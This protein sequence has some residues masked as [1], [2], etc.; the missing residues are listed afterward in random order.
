MGRYRMGI[1][2]GGTFTDFVVI[3]LESG[4][5]ETQKVLTTPQDPSEGIMA[6]IERLGIS[7]DEVADISH[8]TTTATN[9]LI[10]RRGARTAFLT[11]EGFRDTLEIRRSNRKELYD[12]QWY[13]PPPLVPRRNR[14][15]IRERMAWDGEVVLPLD[16]AQVLDVVETL[17]IREI[18]AV[19]ICFLHAY[20]HP[21]HERRVREL[22]RQA[23]PDAFVTTSSEITQEFREFERGSTVAAN[24]FLGPRVKLYVQ[25]LTKRLGEAGYQSDVTIMQSNGGVCT[26][27]EAANIPAKLARSGPAGG[28]MALEQVAARTGLENLVGIDIGGTSADVSVI[29]D[30]R[31]KWT[32]PLF[33]EWGLPLLFPSV[34]VESIGAGG[35]SIAWIDEGRALHM[36]PQSAGADPGPACYGYGGTQ[37]TSTDAHVVLGRVSTDRFLDGRL[38]L[39]PELAKEAIRIHVAEALGLGVHEAAE[40]MLKILDN[41][42]LQAIRYVTIEKGYDPRDFA[43]VGL[44]GGGPLHVASLARELGIAKAVVPMNPGVLSA[45]GL[46]TVDLVQDRSRTILKRRRALDEVALSGTLRELRASIEEAFSR[47]GVAPG[48]ILYEYFLDLQYYGQAFSLAVGLDHLATDAPAER[49]GDGVFRPSEEGSLSIPLSVTDAGS[50]TVT[51]EAMEAA[52]ERFHQEHE[53][54][55]GHSDREQEVQVVHARVF[56]RHQVAKPTISA[57]EPGGQDPSGALIGRRPVRFDGAQ[58]DAPAYDRLLLRAGNAIAGPAVIDE[59]SSTTALP[60]GTTARVDRYGNLLLEIG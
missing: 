46:L 55:Y 29:V 36:G 56:G 2:V 40:G 35:G 27:E 16:E 53:R 25:N 52:T 47:S 31:S 43:L 49:R 14:F 9:A 51:S 33:V 41:N 21:A 13:P 18:E 34:D 50:V 6:G 3:D 30:G 57:A 39:Q 38:K 19:A 12:G 37:A 42:M 54:E 4:T 22:V 28:A 8:G 45:W 5:L 1:D 60:P 20:Q 48:E 59:R 11:T 17:R 44:G 24:A 15:G 26:T 23:M 7:L 58:H 10:E 32:S